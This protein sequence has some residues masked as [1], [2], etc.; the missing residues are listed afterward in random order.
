MLPLIDLLLTQVDARSESIEKKIGRL[1]AELVKYKD[2]MKKMR[3]GPS[4]VTHNTS[5]VGMMMVTS[6][7]CKKFFYSF[8]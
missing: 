2:Q 1:D 5:T 7:I 4:K 6:L 3:D 8:L